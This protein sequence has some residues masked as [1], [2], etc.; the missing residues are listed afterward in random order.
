MS[1][2]KFVHLHVHSVFS[3]LDSTCRLDRLVERVGELGMGA[4]GVT[5]HDG[6]Y[7]AVRF[8]RAARE[9]GVRPILGVELTVEDVG[10]AS[11]ASSRTT[12]Y[13]LPLLAM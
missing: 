4:V 7:G 2:S 3:F 9:A 10:D 1:E 8:Y 13:H 12:G 5:D 6:M 11:G